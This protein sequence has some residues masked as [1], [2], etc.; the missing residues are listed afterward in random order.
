MEDRILPWQITAINL[1]TLADEIYDPDDDFKRQVGY[2]LVDVGVETLF[3]VFLTLP[4]IKSEIGF[5]KRKNLAKSPIQKDEIPGTKVT[6]IEFDKLAFHNLADAVKRVAGSKI[7]DDNL[8]NAEY[9]HNIRNKIYHSGDGIVPTKENFEQ[10]LHLAKFF[11]HEL[12]GADWEKYQTERK[13]QGISDMDYLGYLIGIGKMQSEFD[14]LRRDIVGAVALYNPL[15]A[16]KKFEDE[17]KL[18]WSEF[19]DILDAIPEYSPHYYEITSKLAIK[20]NKVTG[21]NMSDAHE[22]LE[23][24]KDVTYFQLAIL[25]SQLGENVSSELKKYVQCREYLDKHKTDNFIIT[26]DDVAKLD[27]YENWVGKIQEKSNLLIEAKI[28]EK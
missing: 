1:I 24:C 16:T 13:Y 19:I 3:K 21:K 25:L 15:Y 12:L 18:I 2:L 26:Q 9:Y 11:L 14:R 5:T 4:D 7:T 8:K 23:A 20:F 17:L 6:K 22:F 28:S 10:Y 27:E